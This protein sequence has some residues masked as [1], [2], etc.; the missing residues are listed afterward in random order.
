MYLKWSTLWNTIICAVHLLN[1]HQG[2]NVRGLSSLDPAKKH[3]L[4][5][6]MWKSCLVAKT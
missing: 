3:H 4:H 6:N 1:L 5:G 2:L